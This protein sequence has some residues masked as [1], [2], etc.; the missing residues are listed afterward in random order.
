MFFF[1]KKSK[2]IIDCFTNNPTA[3]ELTPIKKALHFLPEWWK[4]CESEYRVNGILR[5]TAKKCPGIIDYYKTG[6]VIPLWSDLELNVLNN[7]ISYQFADKVSSID[8][9]HEG[10]WNFMIDK[11]INNVIH[12]KIISPWRLKTKSHVNFL[13]KDAYYNNQPFNFLSTP[14]ATLNF[15][16]Q[17][18]ANI[19]MFLNLKENKT[20]FLKHQTPLAH[21]IPLSERNVEIKNHLVSNQEFQKI[22]YKHRIAF[23]N[24]YKIVSNLLKSKKKCPF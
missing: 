12:L 19:N 11:E 18:T 7:Q 15:K 1:I 8:F 10:E 17:N 2:I 23:T 9:H 16:D 20:Y 5:S 4:N 13:F 3:Y 6:L 21:I 24:N 22:T 14:S